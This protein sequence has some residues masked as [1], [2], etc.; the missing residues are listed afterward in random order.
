MAARC[1]AA[2]LP[3]RSPADPAADEEPKLCVAPGLLHASSR[4]HGSKAPAA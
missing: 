2:E 1:L 4:R 3:G